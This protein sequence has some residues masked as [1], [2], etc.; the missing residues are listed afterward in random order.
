MKIRGGEEG[1]S[2]FLF[3]LEK[4]REKRTKDRKKTALLSPSHPLSLPLLKKNSKTNMTIFLLI[5]LASLHSLEMETE[6]K[7]SFF[8][9]RSSFFWN[10][11]ERKKTGFVFLFFLFSSLIENELETRRRRRKL[12]DSSFIPSHLYSLEGRNRK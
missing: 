3:L 1:K 9:S 8:F 4:A 6:E 10:G 12:A 7:T 5:F 2:A 11:Q